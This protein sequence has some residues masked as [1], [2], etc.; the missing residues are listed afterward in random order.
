MYNNGSDQRV[1]PSD[2]NINT[3]SCSYTISNLD[4]YTIYVIDVSSSTAIGEGPHS[5]SIVIRTDISSKF[6]GIIVHTFNC[7]CCHVIL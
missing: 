2:C 6:Y 4:P 1:E 3:L 7:F 5:D